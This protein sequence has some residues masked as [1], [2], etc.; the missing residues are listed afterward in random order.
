M[1]KSIQRF[2]AAAAVITALACAPASAATILI[3]DPSGLSAEVEF[4]LVN[5]TTLTVRAKNTSTGAPVGFTGADQ[6]LTS[7][8]WDFG[9]STSITGGSVRTGPTSGSVNFSVANVG[10]SADVSGEYGFGN[11]GTTG[12][13]GNFISGNTAGATPFGGTNL[14]GPAGL[15]GPQGGLIASPAVVS[16][17]GLGA[18][19]DEWIATL[20][21]ASPLANLDF[22]DSGILVEYGSD[23][24]FLPGDPDGGIIPEPGTTT[25]AVVGCAVIFIARGLRRRRE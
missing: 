21:L 9:G 10:P 24:A 3:S 1:R 12:L 8:S 14:D 4:S 5:P 6:I 19:Q 17:G 16:L 2:L 20:T 25:L 22:L 15:N 18:I 11:G 7:V 23:A 13:F